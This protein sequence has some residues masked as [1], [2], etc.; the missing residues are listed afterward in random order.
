MD[1]GVGH[2]GARSIEVGYHPAYD[3]FGRELDERS[4]QFD[5][6]DDRLHL[7]EGRSPGPTQ[8]VCEPRRASPVE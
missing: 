3:E 8:S 2:C 5:G 7:A 4:N 6:P 1:A